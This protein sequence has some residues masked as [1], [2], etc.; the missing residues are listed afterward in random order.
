MDIELLAQTAALRAGDGA[1]RVEQQLRA[2]GKSGFLSQSD[3]RALL[4]AYRLCWR[5]QAGSRLLTDRALDMDRLG[6]GG[7]RFLIRESG[8]AEGDDL[9]RR[10]EQ[11]VAEA[12]AIIGA[13]IGATEPGS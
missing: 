13:R 12:A 5:V 4:D 1:R 10:L 3:E 7:R 11:A 8:A 2:G 6:E 9:S